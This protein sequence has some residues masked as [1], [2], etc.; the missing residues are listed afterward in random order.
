M[1]TWLVAQPLMTLTRPKL[2]SNLC[3]RSMNVAS[4]NQGCR[5]VT[6]RRCFL[7]R[8]STYSHIVHIF[9]IS[10]PL[11]VIDIKDLFAS[12]IGQPTSAVVDDQR[13]KISM[14]EVS[15]KCPPSERDSQWRHTRS[16]QTCPRDVTPHKVKV[17][18]CCQ[19]S[20]MDVRFQKSSRDW[21]CRTSLQK[22]RITARNLHKMQRRFPTQTLP[23][24]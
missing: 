21:K 15:G 7:S 1:Y 6:W 10:N 23:H 5:L 14:L 18:Q 2:Y 22:G 8:S 19:H 3:S 9:C 17:A 13:K 20:H 16:Y 24:L 11:S 12:G 4:H